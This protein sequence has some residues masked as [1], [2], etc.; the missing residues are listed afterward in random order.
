MR[1]YF[2]L[3][4]LIVLLGCNE[5][6]QKPPYLLVELDRSDA[7]SIQLQYLVNDFQSFDTASVNDN[8]MWEFTNDSVPA[9]FYQ[10]VV[11]R[12]PIARLVLSDGA[13]ARISIS[14][15]EFKVTI[16]GS[17]EAKAIHQ[18]E[19]HVAKLSKDINEVAS[20][21]QDSLPADQF[22]QVRDSL[23]ERIED[24]KENCRVKLADIYNTYPGSLVQLACLYQQA[25]N[26]QL[27]DP[28]QDAALY[29]TTDSLLMRSYS[30][31]QPVIGFHHKV[32]SLRRLKRMMDLTSTIVLGR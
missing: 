31:Y 4:G 32:D 19:A 29:F 30:D 9:G 26:Y 8:G 10:L 2:F 15:N 3:I 11:D 18:M 7:S 13:P 12:Q 28:I 23:F 21:F 14:G 16:V 20:S 22:F 24:F 17:P 1:N 5:K 27:F 25:G 6:R